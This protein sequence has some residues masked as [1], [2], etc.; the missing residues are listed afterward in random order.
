MH[1]GGQSKAKLHFCGSHLAVH[2]SPNSY[3]G[4]LQVCV[5]LYIISK[6]SCCAQLPSEQ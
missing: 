5:L 6:A 3:N 1:L 4:G 2:N